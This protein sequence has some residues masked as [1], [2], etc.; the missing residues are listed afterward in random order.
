MAGV[1]VMAATSGLFAQSTPQPPPSTP[2]AEQ[3]TRAKKP[4]TPAIDAN[5]SSS[6]Q[7][8]STPAAKK[9]KDLPAPDPIGEALCGRESRSRKLADAL[10]DLDP[11]AP[12]ADWPWTTVPAMDVRG[13]AGAAICDG[14]SPEEQSRFEARV[15]TLARL[16]QLLEHGETVTQVRAQ[17]AGIR[18]LDYR[19]P[20][21]PASCAPC[22]SLRQ[23]VEHMQIAA[24]GTATPAARAARGSTSARASAT[25]GD[26]LTPGIAFATLAEQLCPLR[27]Q[28]VALE[29]DVRGRFQYFT[30]TATGIGV[31]EAV[32]VL[33]RP[34]LDGLCP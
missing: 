28:A 27:S 23:I 21:W 6:P 13:W 25:I 4:S 26:R 10:D 11:A 2:A 24:N 15:A 31:L 29:R 18:S 30:W 17:L 5:T 7:K 14:A 19:E 22:A 3:P 32:A 20:E 16:Q 12:P 1:L 34:S 33:Q 9:A 8:A